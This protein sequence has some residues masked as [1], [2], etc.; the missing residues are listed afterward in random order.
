MVGT[1]L[2]VLAAVA[3]YRFAEL[4]TAQGIYADEHQTGGEIPGV[5][6]WQVAGCIGVLVVGVIAGVT[7]TLAW[8]GRRRARARTA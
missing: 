5:Q 1:A 3:L 7:G 6:L 4:W 8:I 2:T